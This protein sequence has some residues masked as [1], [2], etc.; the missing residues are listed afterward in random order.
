MIFQ[1][2]LDNVFV[3]KLLMS[4]PASYDGKEGRMTNRETGHRLINFDQVAEF[5]NKFDSN[6]GYCSDA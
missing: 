6:L 4:K 1:V 5:Y 2:L 3:V